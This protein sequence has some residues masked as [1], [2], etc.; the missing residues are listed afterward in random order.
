[1][2]TASNHHPNA[3]KTA[4]IVR[5]NLSRFGVHIDIPGAIAALI[6]DVIDFLP[7]ADI[8]QFL[9]LLGAKPNGMDLSRAPAQFLQWLLLDPLHGVINLSK[10]DDVREAVASVVAEVLDPII[11]GRPVD[12]MR[13]KLA[14]FNAQI[15][16]VKTWHA[17]EFRREIDGMQPRIDWMVA[18][19]ATDSLLP[20]RPEQLVGIVHSCTVAWATSR[21]NERNDTPFHDLHLAIRDKLVDIL[22]LQQEAP[23]A[24][25]NQLDKG[26]R[27]K[28]DDAESGQQRGTILGRLNSTPPSAVVLVDHSL[29]G[30]TWNVPL[31]KLQLID[32]SEELAGQSFN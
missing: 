19:A 5:T 1:M 23:E 14:L 7:D 26:A 11:Q 30:I 6:I 12:P 29:S 21:L 16:Q 31:N 20:N 25:A 10:R 15:A 18:T 8:K 28:F 24:P 13:S 9:R 3:Q 22:G 32:A 2:I 4:P 17:Y 27:V